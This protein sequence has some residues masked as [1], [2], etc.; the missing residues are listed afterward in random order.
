MFLYNSLFSQMLVSYLR[1][2]RSGPR[3]ILGETAEGLERQRDML[4]KPSST[5]QVTA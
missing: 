2:P 5:C 1:L 3:Q 4:P